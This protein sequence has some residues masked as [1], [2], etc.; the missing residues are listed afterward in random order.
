MYTRA[1]RRGKAIVMSPSSDIQNAAAFPAQEHEHKRAMAPALRFSGSRYWRPSLTSHQI[2]S[3]VTMTSP[4]AA[5]TI[6]LPES[7][8]DTLFWHETWKILQSRTYEICYLPQA[9]STNGL[10]E[11]HAGTLS[12]RTTARRL[13]GALCVRM[14]QQ[15]APPSK[16]SE[17]AVPEG[18]IETCTSAAVQ[19][20]RKAQHFQQGQA[21]RPEVQCRRQ[22]AAARNSNI[23]QKTVPADGVLVLDDVFD[24]RLEQP[25]AL[26]EGGLAPFLRQQH[27][28]WLLS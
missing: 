26:P 8:A 6:G 12:N 15:T 24:Q 10:Y 18:S 11:S 25:A 3:Q 28:A 21:G 7:R 1:G 13:A 22:A 4:K 9:A 16:H 2:F 27:L 20:C 19:L 23:N 17:S 14:L 5:S